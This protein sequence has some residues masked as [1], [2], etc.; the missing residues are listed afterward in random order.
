MIR[1][2]LDANVLFTAAHNP[3]G[4]AFLIISLGTEGLWE[5]YNSAFAAEE[6]RRNLAVKYPSAE[7]IFVELLA[8]IILVPEQPDA[9]YPSA[10]NEKDR[11]IFQAA[12]ACRA[13]HLI[14]GDLAH[15]GSFMG[16]QTSAKD[17]PD[18]TLGLIILTPAR[19]L[20][21]L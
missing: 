13:S 15:F 3:D 5:V 9:P 10:L 14:T 11:P 19:F 8:A 18:K 4:K 21:S 2:F 6:A 12:H 20:L 17:K 16:R 1:L 7:K